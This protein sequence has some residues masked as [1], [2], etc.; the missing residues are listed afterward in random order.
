MKPI[1]ILIPFLALVACIFLGILVFTYV[2]SKRA[3]PQ[4][5]HTSGA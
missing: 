2:E 1:P 3:N 4:M 5:I